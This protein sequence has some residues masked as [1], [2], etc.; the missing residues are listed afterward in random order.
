MRDGGREPG[1]Q[2]FVRGEIARLAQPDERFA[3]AVGLDRH[4]M[5]PPGL[6]LQEL[7]RNR[8]PENEPVERL[9]SAP[10]RS[11]QLSLVVQDEDDLPA[12]FEKPTA[13][14]G[15]ELGVLHNR[16]SVWRRS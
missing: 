14:L 16:R 15:S 1:A 8:L 7:R 13:P 5:G 12:L 3:A 11:D 10:A 2:L 4:L 9:A 6:E